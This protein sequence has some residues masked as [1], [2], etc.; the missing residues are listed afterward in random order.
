MKSDRTVGYALLVLGLILIVLA[1]YLMF[2]VF[3]GAAAP[4]AIFHME[5]ITVTL[6]G[7]ESATEILPGAELSKVV[8]MGLWTILMFFVASA[9]SRIGGLGVKLAREIRVE[10]KRED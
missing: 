10:V 1:V 8:N 7:A 6:P 2:N 3:T 5:S 9:G 4:P